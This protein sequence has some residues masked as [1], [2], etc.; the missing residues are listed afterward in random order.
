MN[1]FILKN[2]YD[3]TL[4]SIIIFLLINDLHLKVVS[5]DPSTLESIVNSNYYQLLLS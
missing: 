5:Y 1:L 3:F 4:S 2:R